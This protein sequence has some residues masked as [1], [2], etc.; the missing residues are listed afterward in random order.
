GENLMKDLKTDAVD[1]I[2]KIS[3]DN[4]CN[5][6]RSY[7]K[8]IKIFIGIKNSTNIFHYGYGNISCEGQ[9]IKDTLFIHHYSSG[10]I[11]LNLKSNLI[12]LDMDRLGNLNLQGE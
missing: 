1:G 7:K 3:N 5:W 2:L 9:L 6:V 4:K 10:D 12:W 8:E 11:N